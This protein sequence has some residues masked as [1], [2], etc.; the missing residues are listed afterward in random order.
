MPRLSEACASQAE[1]VQFSKAPRTDCEVSEDIQLVTES[2]PFRF[3]RVALFVHSMSGGGAE[4]VMLGLATALADRGVYV[5]LVVNRAEGELMKLVPESVRLIDLDS[6]KTI[7]SLMNFGRYIRR[8]LPAVVVSAPLRPNVVAMVAKL[9]FRRDLTVFVRQDSTL[10]DQFAASSFRN[11]LMW[12]VFKYLLPASDGILAVSRGVSDDL[13]SIAPGSSHKVKTLYNPVVW[14]DHSERAMA[15]VDHP[16][17]NDKDV[18]V[19][20]SAGRL[21]PVK[22]HAMLLRAFARVIESRPAR[23][24]ILGEGSERGKLTKLAERLGIAQHVD[25]PGFRDNPLSYMSKS[26]VFVLSSRY[27]GFANV[28]PEAMACGTPVV[29][30]D[31]RSGPSELLEGGKLGRLVPVGDWQAMADAII[32]TLDN[33]TPPDR[34]VARASEFSAE[35]SV[36][37]YLELLTGKPESAS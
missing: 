37:R 32:D 15:P 24:V 22:D 17:F 28:L 12:R 4:R 13:C 14:P 8:E 20:L 11:R 23:L 31:C 5:D 30:T 3:P 19:V 34:L 21:A 10:S 16:W 18:P 27:E 29:S 1:T 26:D 6:N 2:S 7:G 36:D 25:M 9:L 33:P 35:A